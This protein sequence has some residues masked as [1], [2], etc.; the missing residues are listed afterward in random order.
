[1]SKI[2]NVQSSYTAADTLP[3]KVLLDND[4][5]NATRNNKLIPIHI[6][7]IPTNK[8]N[9]NCKYCS[10]ANRNKSEE[11]DFLIAKQ[12]IDKCK[13]LGT[14]A[15]TLTGGGEPL[16]Y[17]HITDLID[18][19]H[20]YDIKIGLTTNGLL[21]DKIPY[22]TLSKV[23]WC[24]ISNDD[25]RKFTSSYSSMLER[26][27]SNVDIDW[28]FSHVIC[29]NYNITE[30]GKIINFANENNFTHVR[31]VSDL[32]NL[33]DINFNNIKKEINH[34]EIEDNKV[35]YQGRKD[36]TH[37]RACYMPFIKPLIGPDAKIYACCGVQYAFEEAT[38]DLPQELCLG[39]ALNIDDIIERSNIPLDGNKCHKCYYDNYNILLK[40][41]M[42]DVKHK[43][44]M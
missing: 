40:S 23:T 35:I 29:N 8:C 18:Y 37:G 41:L 32:L 39:E 31:L 24:R 4:L 11:I 7:F 27:I 42:Q 19:F 25:Y 30:I 3:I 21:L 22:T 2:I 20:S 33:D 10:C 9:L 43:E 16:I 14:K 38:L 12:I 36:F 13:K 17:P 44:F 15:V 34:L 26:V 28:A 1:L 6:Q 5:L